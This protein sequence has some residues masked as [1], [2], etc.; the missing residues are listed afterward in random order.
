MSVL[1]M[2]RCGGGILINH[3]G[4][5]LRG[6]RG[7]KCSILCASRTRVS[8]D[9]FPFSSWDFLA[10]VATPVMALRPHIFLCE[11]R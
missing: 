6:R 3:S 1:A 9:F 5:K 4:E 7:R 10:F 11:R 2:R 8:A